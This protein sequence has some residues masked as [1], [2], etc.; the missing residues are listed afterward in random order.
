MKEKLFTEFLEGIV[1]QND[2]SSSSAGQQLMEFPKAEPVA[3]FCE[4]DV[5]NVE[6]TPM[7]PLFE[8]LLPRVRG[9]WDSY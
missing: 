1:S 3:A 7:F 5:K 8:K 9:N 2:I 6:Q 4:P